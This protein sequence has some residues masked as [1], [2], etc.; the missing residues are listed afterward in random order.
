VKP[1]SLPNVHYVGMGEVKTSARGEIL[2][3][4]LGS[5]IGIGI[6]WRNGGRIGLA[7]C[8]LPETSPAI[9]RIGARYVSQAVPSLLALMGLKPN[10]LSEIEIIVAGGAR[11]FRTRPNVAHVGELN[12]QAVHKHLALHGLTAN[13]FEIGGRRGRQM[14]IDGSQQSFLINEVVQQPKELHDACP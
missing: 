10:N 9:I 14:S 13:H 2:S 6:I 12:V 5:C 3:A 4:T 11:M 1:A 8:L 7:H